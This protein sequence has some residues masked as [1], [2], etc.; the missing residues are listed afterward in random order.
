MA[1]FTRF[2]YCRTESGRMQQDGG[3]RV[4][5]RR[6]PFA[7]AGQVCGSPRCLSPSCSLSPPGSETICRAW[8]TSS[9]HIPT[10]SSAW[11]SR[12]TVDGWPPG[13]ITV[14]SRSGTRTGGSWRRSWTGARAGLR[15]RLL[16]RRLEPRRGPLRW[17]G[18]AL[19]DAIMASAGGSSRPTPDRRGAS[20]SRPTAPS[21]RPAG[22]DGTIRCGTRRPGVA[23]GNLR[24]HGAPGQ[25][26]SVSPPTAG[27]S[28]RRARTGP[29]G[30]G[31]WLRM[32]SSRHHG[33]SV[34]DESQPPRC[35]VFS[36]DGQILTALWPQAG[37]ASWDV[38]QRRE[39][40]EA[41][42]GLGSPVL[43]HGRVARRP[44]AGRRHDRWGS[45]DSGT[46]EPGNAVVP[47]GAT[48]ARWPVLAFDARGRILY[49]G[50][51]DGTLRIWE[52]GQ[53]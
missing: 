6:V 1:T 46:R 3:E 47:S 14:P 27:R 39:A 17:D 7:S 32:R 43:Q 4:S 18:D 9:A 16:A 28:P 11:P 41:G 49:S 50:G 34:A 12:R 35:L 36:P 23:C 44:D 53:P 20:R 25:F 10:G 15:P 51:E 8:K 22:M 29:C 31:T 24:G 48:P 5:T 26:A 33:A 38:P 21:W 13:D 52:P 40:N 2:P 37:L 42:H 19:G 45:R 30:C